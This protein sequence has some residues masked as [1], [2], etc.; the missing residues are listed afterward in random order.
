MGHIAFQSTLLEFDNSHANLKVLL[1][2]L[3]TIVTADA[4]RQR[5][6]F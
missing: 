6:V 5:A 4:L 2:C 3:A 1:Q